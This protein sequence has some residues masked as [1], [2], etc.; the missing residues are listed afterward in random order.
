MEA[1]DAEIIA[2]NRDSLYTHKAWAKKLGIAIPLMSDMTGKVARDYSVYLEDVG[3]STRAVFI[4]DKEGNLH[5]KHR[6]CPPEYTLHTDDI[7]SELK[8]LSA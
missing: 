6:E 7:I 8:K 1:L 4:I 5:F 2:V 3:I